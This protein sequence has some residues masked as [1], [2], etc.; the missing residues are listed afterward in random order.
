MTA[1]MPVIKVGEDARFATAAKPD[2]PRHAGS[3]MATG[4]IGML[5]LVRFY[6]AFLFSTA[7]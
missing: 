7:L 6:G 3:L 1:T 2:A 5:K 4:R